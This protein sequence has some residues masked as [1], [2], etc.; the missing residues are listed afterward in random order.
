M[1]PLRHNVLYY[2]DTQKY[3]LTKAA[4][5]RSVSV[6]VMTS[7]KPK[8]VRVHKITHARTRENQNFE[9]VMRRN[10]NNIMPFTGMPTFGRGTFEG[11]LKLFYYTYL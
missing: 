2:V 7:S 3:I 8:Q 6:E 5:P 11:I 4:D 1:K 10:C 9:L